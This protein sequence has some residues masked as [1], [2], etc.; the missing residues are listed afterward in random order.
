ME[1]RVAELEKASQD[2]REKLAR[3]D[4]RLDTIEKTMATEVTLGGLRTDVTKELGAIR[5]SLSEEA[6]TIN[7]SVSNFRTEI[8]RVEGTMIKWYIVTALA[9]ASGFGAIAFG[10]A[11]ALPR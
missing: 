4:G 8:T 2:I 1:R 3:V 7:Q 11:R 9:L 5:V 6:G 10:L